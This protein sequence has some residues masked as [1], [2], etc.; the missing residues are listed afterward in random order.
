MC[1]DIIHHPTMP[2]LSFDE[3]QCVIAFAHVETHQNIIIACRFSHS[4]AMYYGTASTKSLKTG[5]CFELAP[6][7]AQQ[8]VDNIKGPWPA[9]YVTAIIKMLSKRAGYVWL[10]QYDYYEQCSA[11]TIVQTYI[12]N[13]FKPLFA[14]NKITPELFE[15]AW[16]SGYCTTLTW[17][18]TPNRYHIIAPWTDLCDYIRSRSYNISYTDVISLTCMAIKDDHRVYWST[19]VEK[20]DVLSNPLVI[21]YFKKYM[22]RLQATM[23]C[24]TFEIKCTIFNETGTYRNDAFSDSL[25]KTY[26]DNGIKRLIPIIAQRVK[27]GIKTQPDEYDAL[28]YR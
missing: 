8:I 25:R 26:G 6:R 7:H 4:Q 24:M 27:D 21:E 15:M 14:A 9:C 19:L 12:K 10:P 17:M 5:E 20:Y 18:Y 16:S 23:Y 3:I 2:R 28:I 22:D 1:I 11:K 13:S